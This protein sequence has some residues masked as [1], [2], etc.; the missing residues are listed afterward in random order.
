M[1]RVT[2]L[3][4]RFHCFLFNCSMVVCVTG[5]TEEEARENAA[6]EAIRALEEMGSLSEDQTGDCNN[7]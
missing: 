1:L 2:K 4:D 7:N 3:T 6:K 5:P